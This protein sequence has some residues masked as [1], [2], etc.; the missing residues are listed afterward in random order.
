MKPSSFFD[1][2]ANMLGDWRKGLEGPFQQLGALKPPQWL[3]QAVR[4]RVVL[5]FNHLLQQN[6]EAQERLLPHKHKVLLLQWQPLALR[7]QVTPAGMFDVADEIL[8]ADLTMSVEGNVFQ[9]TKDAML[10]QRPATVV[11]G[12]AAFA[13]EVNWLLDNVRWDG[14]SDLA[15]IIGTEP[16]HQ[17]AQAAHHVKKAL[18]D[19]VDKVAPVPGRADGSKHDDPSQP[20]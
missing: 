10:G 14:E 18:T 12:D 5:L 2:V 7:L 19:F 9:L 3:D 13:T 4:A 1:D 8:R 6:P 11:E 17:I 16:A 15:R 20:G